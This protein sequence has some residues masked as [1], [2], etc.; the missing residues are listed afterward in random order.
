MKW[1]AIIGVFISFSV[2]A[3]DLANVSV[4]ETRGRQKYFFNIGSI[5]DYQYEEPGV[6][7]LHGQMTRFGAGYRREFQIRKRTLWWQVDASY[8]YGNLTYN[9]E[10]QNFVDATVMPVTY[11]AKD[12]IS[13]LRGLIGYALLDNDV[14][15]F[16]LY[17]GLA[18]WMLRDRSEGVGS[19]DRE[20][21][22]FYAPVG[23]EY[24][25]RVGTF[26]WRSYFEINHQLFGIVQ[27][28]LSDANP[29]NPDLTNFQ[30]FG[31]GFKA[32]TAAEW[33]IGSI[34]LTGEIF[35]QLWS[36]NAS[37]QDDVT[38]NGQPAEFQEP[39]NDTE[40]LG[41]DLGLRF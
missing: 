40:M 39:K 30:F 38:V 25:Q 32:S 13:I 5:V 1:F 11:R 31:F 27:S 29:G 33:N 36:M 21:T 34:A 23:A 24:V 22:Y 41:A 28:D 3:E 16:R 8:A 17:V 10:I 20:I 7:R 35:Y 6:M 37:T 4:S 2:A 19:Y 18:T 9:G 26:N 15:A 12:N 14:R